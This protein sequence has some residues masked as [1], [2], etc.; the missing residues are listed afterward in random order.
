MYRKGLLKN[1]VPHGPVIQNN[2]LNNGN[3]SWLIKFSGFPTLEDDGEYNVE[4][5][6]SDGKGGRASGSSSKNYSGPF[7]HLLEQ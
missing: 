7:K 2:W 1:F 5:V 6:D 4:W 3:K